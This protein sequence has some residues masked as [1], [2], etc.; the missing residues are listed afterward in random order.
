MFEHVRMQYYEHLSNSDNVDIHSAIGHE[1]FHFFSHT[2]CDFKFY[3]SLII[4]NKFVFPNFQGNVA[5]HL[6]C[7]GKYMFFLEILYAFKKCKNFENR[8]RSDKV[9]AD[10][11][12]APFYVVHCM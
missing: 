5:T 10:Y 12:V 6:R 9:R 2:Q 3:L 4:F 8:L 1:M 7:G 11:K